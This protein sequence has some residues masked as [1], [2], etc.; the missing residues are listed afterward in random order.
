MG[1]FFNRVIYPPAENVG[2]ICGRRSLYGSLILCAGCR[3]TTLKIVLK[4]SFCTYVPSQQFKSRRVAD[5]SETL[6]KT[7]IDFIQFFPELLDIFSVRHFCVIE[8]KHPVAQIE[9]A[10][11]L[12]VPL[13]VKDISS[14]CLVYLS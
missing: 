8:C 9:K 11:E 12:V 3:D 1:Y 10:S 14:K 5:E 13:L 6:H 4:S 7:V 2:F